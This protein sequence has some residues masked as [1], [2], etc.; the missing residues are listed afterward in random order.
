MIDAHVHLWR[1]GQNDCVWPGPDLPAIHRDFRLSDL[2]YVLDAN[3]VDRAILV[4]SQ[5]SEADTRWLLD[6]AASAPDRI[7]GVV[8]WVDLTAAGAVA[9]IDQ[10]MEAGLLLGLRPMMQDGPDDG[11]DDPALAAGLSHLEARGLV[12]DA[13]VRPRHLSSLLRLA[14]RLPGLRIVIDHA[15]KP[16]IGDVIPPDWLGHMEELSRL[17][18]VACKISGL[19]TELAPGAGPDSVMPV[20]D[21]LIRLFG[22]DRLI[23]GSDWPVMT[24][25]AAYSDWIA[26]TRQCISP[27]NWNAVS[28]DNALRIYGVRS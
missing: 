8:G 3:D 18:H 2:F 11:Y 17:P 1:I 5:P 6:M 10:L 23:W 15:A 26:I 14:S 9:H 7:A 19:L 22:L 21:R 27:A 28:R 24:L 16:L 20:I 12:L 13:L 25:A 4:Q